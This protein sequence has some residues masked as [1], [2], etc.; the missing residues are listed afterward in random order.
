MERYLLR[1]IRTLRPNVGDAALTMSNNK[2]MND[3]SRIDTRLGSISYFA[4]VKRNRDKIVLR[5]GDPF[6]FCQTLISGGHKTLIPESAQA[7]LAALDIDE[8]H[9][10]VSSTYAVLIGDDRRRELSAY[11]TPPALARAAIEASDRFLKS[12]LHPTVL[13]PACGGGSFLTPVTRHLVKQKRER[14]VPLAEAC[15]TT[16]RDIRG[17]EIDAGLSALSQA[18]L[19]D[20]LAHEFRYFRSDQPTAV[21][22]E[23]A[24]SAS[25]PQLY[26]LV[27]GNP[28]YGKIGAGA[29]E[30]LL[31]YAGLADMGGHTN[32]YSLFLLR[33]L[34]WLKPG[35]GLV[36]VLPTSFV[37]GPYFSGLRQELL[38]RAEVLRIDLHEQRE[39]LFLGAV[40]DVCLLTMQRRRSHRLV[41]DPAHSYELGTIDSNGRRN[42]CGKG[43][44]KADGEPWM[45]PVAQLGTG[46]AT[47]GNRRTGEGVSL[48]V[49]ADYGYRIR[50]GKVV[51]TRER[52]RLHSTRQRGDFPLLWASAIRPDGSFDFKASKR[53]GNA[54]WYSPPNKD[55][56][57]YATVRAAVI[58]QRT[59]NRDQKRRLNAAA[60]PERFRNQHKKGFIAENHVIVL[61][62]IN[63]SP[64]VTPARLARLLNSEIVNE[65]F[66]AVSGTFSVSAKL[67][68]RLALPRPEL[69]KGLNSKDLEEGLRE[70][71]IGTEDVLAP[72][73]SSDN[74]SDAKNP[75]DKSGDLK[76][77][78]S[79]DK[80]AGFKRR[81]VA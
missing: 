25:A 27:I 66:S 68:Q 5:H 26:D 6:A 74:T 32:L 38:A 21:R 49:L 12:R 79:V 39:N 18:L 3:A 46:R 62:A 65:R 76:R 16:L 70:L 55:D 28:P 2:D 81:A 43:I 1:P 40:Q 8:R 59:S 22:C 63:A 58:V 57:G 24:L 50:V 36:F 7:L 37:A 77:R 80:N 47:I 53:L 19:N 60:V 44:A 20:M 52:A 14:G 61:E 35:G 73:A 4:Y 23:D 9:Y 15:K 71:F 48:C 33:S 41:G 34:D 30:T 67:L 75:T 78:L 42:P 64:A 11:F 56:V 17:I 51:P 31:R 13:D 72:L 29:D 54:S 10:L 45:L 69:V